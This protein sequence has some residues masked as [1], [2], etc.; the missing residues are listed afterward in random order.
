LEAEGIRVRVF[1]R[2]GRVLTGVLM[3]AP[4]GGPP[5]VLI[6]GAAYGPDDSI[7]GDAIGG[8]SADP[9]HIDS[10]LIGLFNFHARET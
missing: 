3:P 10:E 9:D 4:D 7:Q 6:D 8:V 5:I 2:G 1:T